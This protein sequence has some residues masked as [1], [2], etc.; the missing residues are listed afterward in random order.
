MQMD[1]RR[2][3]EA[4]IAP[5]SPGLLEMDDINIRCQFPHALTERSVRKMT[6]RPPKHR[7]PRT[8]T[9]LHRIHRNE[10]D[11]YVMRHLGVEYVTS[12]QTAYIDAVRRKA[13]H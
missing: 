1:K 12:C 8:P 10:L 7:G 9:T 5:R 6:A 13:S 3:R 2:G 4:V 11:R